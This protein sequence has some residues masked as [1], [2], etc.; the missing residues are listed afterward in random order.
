MSGDGNGDQR[1]LD[2]QLHRHCEPL[3]FLDA[4]V[5]SGHSKATPNATVT[6]VKHRNWYYAVTCGHVVDVL[7]NKDKN[8]DGRLVLATMYSR[9]ISR[10]A[11]LDVN[12]GSYRTTFKVPSSS[13]LGVGP[14]IAIHPLGE[15]MSWMAENKG[16]L[17]IDLD[18]WVEPQWEK[19]K[20]ACAV[21]FATEH[22]STVADKVESW[23]HVVTAEVA[24]NLGPSSEKITISATLDKPHGRFFSGMSGGALFGDDSSD[25]IRPI[26]IVVQGSPGGSTGWSNRGA[27]AFVTENDI[28]IT[29]LVLSP[30]RFEQWLIAVGLRGK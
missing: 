11:E 24:S 22:K 12:S 26:G 29:G 7:S 16:K 9:S 21:G 30:I 10:Y 17:P 14:D 18:T 8:P 19:V 25:H 1:E 4:F 23:L 2:R 3:F 20:Y 5:E 15:A 27:Q 13:G 6:Y 28:V